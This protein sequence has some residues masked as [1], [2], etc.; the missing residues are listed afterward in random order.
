MKMKRVV[1]AIVALALGPPLAEAGSS[2]QLSAEYW[3]RDGVRVALEPLPGDGRRGITTPRY[4]SADGGAEREAT[5]RLYV[6]LAD[7]WEEA[8]V[9]ALAARY[10]MSPDG[11]T[12]RVRRFLV[13]EPARALETAN[14]IFETEGV[15]CASPLWRKS[16]G[17]RV[18]ND[19]L[20]DDQWHLD[21]HGQGGGLVGADLGAFDAWNV[22]RGAGVVV[23]VVDDGVEIAHPD[24]VDNVAAAW[25]RDHIEG[26]DDPTAGSHGT[27]VAGIVAAVGDNGLGGAGVAP[28]ASLVGLRVMDDF[29]LVDEAGVAEAFGGNL[30]SID[31]LNNSWGPPDTALH[32]FERPSTLEMAAIDEATGRGRGGLGQIFVWAGGNGGESDNSNLDGYASLRQTIAVTASTNMGG[33]AYYAEEGANL[34]VNAPSSGG[35]REIV[36]TDRSGALGDNSGQETWEIDDVDYTDSFS[37]TSASTPAVSGVIALMLAANPRLNWREVQQVL[38]ASAE[39]NDPAHVSWRRNA[40]GYWI[41]EQFGFGRVDAAA[42][43]A[44]ARD[45]G[46][47]LAAEAATRTS[48]RDTALAIP[49]EDPTGVSNRLYVSDRVRVEFVEVTVDIDHTYWGDLSLYLTSPAGSVV[50]LMTSRYLPPGARSLGFRQWTLGDVLHLGESSRGNWTL[51][52]VDEIGQDVGTLR[53]WAIRVHGAALPAADELRACT[54]V[55][56]GDGGAVAGADVRLGASRHGAAAA[57]GVSGTAREDYG[58]HFSVTPGS[59]AT[60]DEYLLLARYQPGTGELIDYRYDGAGWRRWSGDP[61]TLTG[62]AAAELDAGGTLPLFM[63]R[64]DAGA[65]R[66]YGGYRESSGEVVYCPQPITV[67]VSG[68]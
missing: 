41:S 18:L 48:G 20:L 29:G 1:P 11:G 68:G 22:T 65:Y 23:G 55:R 35:S 33:A 57:A 42:A 49:D 5:G 14:A 62:F 51:R 36:T 31:I 27:P 40:A 47:S 43:V 58:I 37:G 10:D 21:N 34:L 7:G 64:L 6:C 59:G 24:L 53:S 26:D 60:V 50:R 66:L 63:G 12:E 2:E 32:A 19:P 16:M 3:Y 4:R 15:S 44:L 56:L 52:V 54:P 9:A 28:E 39:R 67:E 25:N 30:Y 46:A 38:A 13:G 61:A 8:E 45:W 17:R